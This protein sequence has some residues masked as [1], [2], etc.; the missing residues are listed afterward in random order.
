MKEYWDYT[1]GKYKNSHI[2]TRLTIIL[3]IVA[4][5]A[6]VNTTL[7]PNK[8]FRKLDIIKKELKL[9]ED[10]I[11]DLKKLSKDWGESLSKLDKKNGKS[12]EELDK[13]MCD[14]EKKRGELIEKY[15]KMIDNPKLSSEFKIA[16]KDINRRKRTEFFKRY[17]GWLATGLA[18]KSLLALPFLLGPEAGAALK[19]KKKLWRQNKKQKKP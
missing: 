19:R 3:T 6:A 12:L 13:L 7:F 11:N 18:F 5:W 16:I 10:Q 9:N 17:K 8:Q 4:L 14:F 2:W 1:Y 15:K